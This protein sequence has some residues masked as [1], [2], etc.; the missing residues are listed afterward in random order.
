MSYTFENH[1]EFPENS[2][3]KLILCKEGTR[4]M[5]FGRMVALDEIASLTWEAAK[6]RLKDIMHE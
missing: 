5:L 2:V 3:G 1:C 6:E 4:V